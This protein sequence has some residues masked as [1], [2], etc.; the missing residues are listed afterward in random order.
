MLI[1]NRILL[2]IVIVGTFPLQAMSPER[3]QKIQ[4][5][6]HERKQHINN[7]INDQ[8]DEIIKAIGEYRTETGA[9]NTQQ[10]LL[11]INFLTRNLPKIYNNIANIILPFLENQKVIAGSRVIG[12]SLTRL[13]KTI[14]SIVENLELL[15]KDTNLLNSKFAQGLWRTMGKPQ[16][17]YYRF[18]KNINDGI[19]IGINKWKSLQRK[20]SQFT[21]IQI[22]K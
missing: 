14:S 4:D 1:R 21:D 8:I 11:K 13:N 9:S 15:Q 20:I 19:Q 22:S 17:E 18:K 16:Y 3:L 7:A 10:I 12:E 6:S 5:I 2:L